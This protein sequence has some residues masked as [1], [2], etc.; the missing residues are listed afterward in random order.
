MQQYHWI[1]S[2]YSNVKNKKNIQSPIIFVPYFLCL[3]P[4]HLQTLLSNLFEH[5]ININVPLKLISCSLLLSTFASHSHIFSAENLPKSMLMMWVR[6]PQQPLD[7]HLVQLKYLHTNL[8]NKYSQL[9]WPWAVA[10]APLTGSGLPSL[11]NDS[12]S[13]P[14]K[15][16][17]KEASLPSTATYSPCTR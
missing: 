6:Q 12:T 9:K 2:S 5:L 16:P 17:I 1:L 3:A 7:N 14:N 4:D 8:Y 11:Q 15:F 10:T 13:Y